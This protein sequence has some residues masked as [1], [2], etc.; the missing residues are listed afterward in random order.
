MLEFV[1]SF[2]LSYVKSKFN[3]SSITKPG[4]ELIDFSNHY[5][6]KNI[7]ELLKRQTLL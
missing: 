1:N 7:T 5:F 4:G 2:R 3:V 6:L